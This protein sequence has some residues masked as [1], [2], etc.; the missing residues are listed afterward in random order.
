MHVAIKISIAKG[1]IE[2]LV[3]HHLLSHEGTIDPQIIFL[4]GFYH[5]F[6]FGYEGFLRCK[7]DCEQKDRGPSALKT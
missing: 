2:V 5:P 1:Q 4:S 3:S 7:K 6:G